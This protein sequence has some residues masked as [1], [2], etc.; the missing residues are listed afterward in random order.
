MF[1][2]NIFGRRFVCHIRLQCLQDAGLD[3]LQNYFNT[4]QTPNPNP[5]VICYI[6]KNYIHK[7]IGGKIRIFS[8]GQENNILIKRVY[9]IVK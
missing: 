9:V 7:I 5:S 8:L 2:A 6:L 3:W 4:I 1:K